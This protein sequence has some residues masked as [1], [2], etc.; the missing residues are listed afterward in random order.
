MRLNLDFRDFRGARQEERIYDKLCNVFGLKE[1]FWPVGLSLDF[2]RRF[3]GWGGGM[4]RYMLKTRM[5]S[6]VDFFGASC[7]RWL[8]GRV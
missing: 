7:P 8:S 4:A 2:A 6:A 5:P 1:K 3:Y